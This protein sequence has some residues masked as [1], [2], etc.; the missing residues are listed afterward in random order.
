MSN[1]AACREVGV[2]RKTGNRWTYGRTV[3]NRNGKDYVYAPIAKKKDGQVSDR[4]LSEDERVQ[5]AD[6][7]CAG[8]SLRSIA[9]RLGRNPSTI[10]RELHRNSNPA[11]GAYQPFQ[12]QRRAV[13]RRA[14]SKEGKLRRDPEL[15]E[16]V[17]LHL[18]KR[19]SPEQISRALPAAFPGQPERH[20]STETIYQAIYLPHRGGLERA[21][22]QLRTRRKHRRKRRRPD[23]RLTRF[24]V[25]GLTIN[26][27]PTEAAGRAVPGHW[28]GD[29]IVGKDNRSAIGTLVDRTTRYVKRVASFLF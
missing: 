27:R 17:E 9:R 20:L 23:Q 26:E 2:N 4:F 13:A 21:P 3:K 25:T 6:L 29:L 16:F 5:I 1:S 7:L 22:G 24:R 15:K 14:R 28:E 11:T 10:S 18:G 19:W 12:A 8:H